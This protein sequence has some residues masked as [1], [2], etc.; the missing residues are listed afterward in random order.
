MDHVVYG[1]PAASIPLVQVH[2]TSMSSGRCG[3]WSETVIPSSPP[4]GARATSLVAVPLI[5]LPRMLIPIEFIESNG[6]GVVEGRRVAG[7]GWP[8]EV[9]EM[10]GAVEQTVEGVKKASSSRVLDERSAVVECERLCP[11][12]AASTTERTADGIEG[13]E[14]FLGR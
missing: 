8:R 5:A 13:V 1:A 6:R 10:M 11:I 9:G 7:E 2:P 14:C 4:S 12:F 3:D